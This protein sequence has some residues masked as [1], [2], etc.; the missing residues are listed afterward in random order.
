MKYFFGFLICIA[1]IVGVF[2]LVFRGFSGHSTPKNQ[3]PLS[4]YA[5]SNTTVQMTVDGPIV[6]DQQHQAYRITV[7]KDSTTVQ[8]FQGYNSTVVASKTYANTEN[9]YNNFLRALD[10][11]GFSKGDSKSVSTD[12]R[13]VC[14]TGDR[15]VFEILT[16]GNSDI[17]R[18]W[19]T[20]CSGQGTFKGNANQVKSLF[21]KQVPT[22]DYGAMISHLNL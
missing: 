12:E 15:Y 4:S 8:T 22:A 3:T 6:A 7:G 17:Q 16:D 18:Y 14:A 20:S 10:L 5:N 11:A 13:G 1:L 9:G 21:N 19:S 2:I